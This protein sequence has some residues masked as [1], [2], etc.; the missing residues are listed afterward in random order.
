[1][2]ST[3]AANVVAVRVHVTETTRSC[4]Q[5][6]TWI[7]VSAKANSGSIAK[8]QH[9]VPMSS[10]F[11][12]NTSKLNIDPKKTGFI[13][14]QRRLKRTSRQDLQQRKPIKMNTPKSW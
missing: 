10:L 9:H 2:D 1:M 5:S 8:I 14:I 12:Q 11:V 3:V 7:V 4:S 6:Y 13:E